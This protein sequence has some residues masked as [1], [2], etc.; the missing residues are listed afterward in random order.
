MKSTNAPK[1]PVLS[2]AKKKIELKTPTVS[3]VAKP[4]LAA[5][6]NETL[7]LR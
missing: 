3:K 7:V 6:H 2:A 5:N 4:R 1:N